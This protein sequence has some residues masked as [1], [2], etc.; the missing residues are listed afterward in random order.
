MNMVLK[1]GWIAKAITIGLAA[2]MVIS[3]M[4]QSTDTVFAGENDTYIV[5]VHDKEGI[6]AV[7][8]GYHVVDQNGEALTLE[9]SPSEAAALESKKEILCVEKDFTMGNENEITPDL[10]KVKPAEKDWNLKAVDAVNAASTQKVKVAIIDSGVDYSENVLIQ[11]RKDFVTDNPVTTPLYEDLTGH[12]T[13]VASLL[14]GTKEDGDVKG[15]D[16]NI[17]LYSARVLDEKN[18]AP[19]S[20]VVAA[21]YW[22]MEKKVNI[23]NISFGTPVYSEALKTAVD[24]AAEQGIL[25]VA[26]AGNRGSSGV[27]Y[28]AAF[29]NVLSVGSVNAAGGVSDFSAK[30]DGVDVVAPGEAV[31]A[32]AHFGQDYVLSGTSLAA[33][34]VAGIAALL[35][36]KDLTKPATF[37]KTLIKTSAKPMS[38]AGSGYGLVDYA[39]ALQIYDDAASQFDNIAEAHMQTG[40]NDNGTQKEGTPSVNGNEDIP[41]E[42]DASTSEN[43]PPADEKDPT[44]ETALDKEKTAENQL[45]A[46]AQT[47]EPDAGRTSESITEQDKATDN[48]NMPPNGTTVTPDMKTENE[49]KKELQKELNSMEF[50]KTLIKEIAISENSGQAADLSDPVVDGSWVAKEHQAYAEGEAM[51]AGAI[52]PDNKDQKPNVYGM[53]SHPEFH[54]YS[55]HGSAAW[56][57]GVCNYVANY[58]YLIMVANRIGDDLDDTKLAASSVKGL[59]SDCYSE[60]KNG[61]AIIKTYPSYKKYTTRRNKKAFMMGVAMHTATDAFA[62]SAFEQ[63]TSGSWSWSRILHPDADDETHIARRV[64]MA[65]AVER[66]VVAR[67]NNQ[68]GNEKIGND[69]H[70][71]T[72]GLYDS[73]IG[74]R[75]NKIWTFASAADV[76]KPIIETHFKKLQ[77]L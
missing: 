56:N 18:Q 53:T 22:A 33:P 70:A 34:Q 1:K 68:R 76:T 14:A 77:G 57:Q 37:I 7:K 27:D 13:S 43:N 74:F 49:A 2:M 71:D 41:V 10:N 60:L 65:Y 59:R 50:E 30:G 55:W 51:K 20:R 75:L 61:V 35:W 45:S 62:H 17:Q 11:E 21:I 9:I 32:Q 25:V 40:V 42:G 24:A 54:G 5:I 12:G 26:A 52:A 63:S 69:F 48:K 36:S 67:F 15:L 19:V 4:Y 46:A 3:Y 72:G 23:I 64:Q 31:L 8:D 28:P 29:D 73:P 39:Y 58:K 47:I 6:A 44:D 16:S 66:N 38:D